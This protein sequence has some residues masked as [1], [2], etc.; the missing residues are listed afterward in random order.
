[1]TGVANRRD[2][3]Q[4][5]IMIFLQF[6]IVQSERERIGNTITTYLTH[7]NNNCKIPFISMFVWNLKNRLNH[8]TNWINELNKTLLFGIKALVFI[9][10]HIYA[11]LRYNSDSVHTLFDQ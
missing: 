5:M 7:N 10:W 11:A 4:T 9:G 6:D 8:N 3:T 2:T 1:M